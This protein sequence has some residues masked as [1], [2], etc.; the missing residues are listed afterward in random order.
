[1]SQFCWWL[2]EIVSRVLEPDERDAVRGDIA[3]SGESAGRALG[4]VLGLVARRQ[5]ALWKHWHSWTALVGLVVPLG[6]LLCLVSRRTAD[7]SA[8]H[9]WLYANNWDWNFFGNAA[10]RHD[11]AYYIGLVLI[12]YLTLFCWSW[13][14]GFVLGSASGGSL[15]I[16]GVLFVLMLLFGELLGAPP[17]HFGYALYYR[18]R[19][20]SSNATVF[21]LTFYRV[22][23]PLVVRLFLVLVP[24]V[25][26][27][28]Q[29]ISVAR[30][31]P[32]FRTILWTAAIATLAAIAIRTGL[33]PVWPLRQLNSSQA[34]LLQ[35]VVYWPIG[36]LVLSA[37]GRRRHGRI[38]SF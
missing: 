26:G 23:F 31:R 9:I 12:E 22:I 36:Y 11:L 13:S 30:L 35:L 27:M 28:R 4:D 17:R 5:S 37:I 16:Q 2:V 29:A 33:V 8:V 1:M 18:A 19:D 3:E 21:Q 6:M 10:F 32:L 34:P 7:G 15:P 20:F 38:A 24:S 14:S 25:W